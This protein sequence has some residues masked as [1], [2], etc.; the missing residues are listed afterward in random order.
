MGMHKWKSEW[1][2]SL[3]LLASSISYKDRPLEGTTL[4]TFD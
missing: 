2:D 4:V 3:Q 1:C